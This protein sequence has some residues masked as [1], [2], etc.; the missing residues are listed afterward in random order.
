MLTVIVK[1]A[2]VFR[3][4]RL[5]LGIIGGCGGRRLESLQPVVVD[6]SVVVNLVS[7]HVIHVV[8]PLQSLIGVE[9]SEWRSDF[10]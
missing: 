10:N 9:E 7:V 4:R 8:F 6:G 3:L 5:L 2:Y 1:G